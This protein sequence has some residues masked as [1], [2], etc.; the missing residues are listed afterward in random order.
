MLNSF[1]SIRK[2]HL[3]FDLSIV[4]F[5]SPVFSVHEQRRNIVTASWQTVNSL[6]ISCN[7]LRYFCTS[8]C[9]RGVIDFFV[10]YFCGIFLTEWSGFCT[11]WM[12]RFYLFASHVRDRLAFWGFTGFQI[13]QWVFSELV[14][15]FFDIFL[16]DP[17]ARKIVRKAFLCSISCGYSVEKFIKIKNR[18][19]Q[20]HVTRIFLS[21][22]FPR[23]TIIR[24]KQLNNRWNWEKKS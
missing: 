24:H 2:F 9:P 10:V 17:L 16:E 12:N 22:E 21:L 4:F 14:L 5:R 13:R 23:V 1:S 6:V 20:G 7:L 8:Q 19:F 11:R 3:K 18:S 15:C